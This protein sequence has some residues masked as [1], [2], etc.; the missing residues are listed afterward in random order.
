MKTCKTQ[1]EKTKQKILDWQTDYVEFRAYVQWSL[2]RE[3]KKDL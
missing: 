1:E 3:N 2:K